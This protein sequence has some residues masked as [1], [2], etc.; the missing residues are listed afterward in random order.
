M[1]IR[2]IKPEFFRDPDTTGRWPAD[3][4]IFYVGMWM[5]ADD[6]GRSLRACEDLLTRVTGARAQLLSR[7]RE[8]LA[9]YAYEEALALFPTQGET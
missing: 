1:R 2:S 8:H 4:K 6:D 3:L 9:A 7:I 5:V